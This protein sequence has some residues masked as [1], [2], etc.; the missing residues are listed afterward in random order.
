MRDPAV[1]I[2]T[3]ALFALA[4]SGCADLNVPNPNSPTGLE[5][6][7]TPDVVEGHISGAY[8]TWY[9]GVHHH[10]NMTRVANLSF[11]SSTTSC[12][13]GNSAIPRAPILND[14]T[15]Y[16]YYGEV[17]RTWERTYAALVAVAEG[18]GALDAHPEMSADLNAET[19]DG[20]L[21]LRAFGRTVQ[22]LGH[23]TLAVFY[24]KGVVRD[25]ATDLTADPHLVSYDQLFQ[26]ADGYFDDAIDLAESGDFTIPAAWMS[27]DVTSEE[28]AALLHAW[29]AI[30][31]ASLPR[32]EDQAVDW[33]AVLMDLDRSLTSTFAMQANYNAGWYNGAFDV[34]DG[35]NGW[36][37]ES[38]FILGMADQ[39]GRYQRWLSTP[40]RDRLPWFGTGRDDDP[41]L[42]VTPDTRFPR[43][44]TLAEQDAAPGESYLIPRDDPWGYDVAE[45]F[46]N[47]GRGTWRWSY[48]YNPVSWNYWYGFDH[49]VP[50]I[51]TAELD[52]LRAE[53]LLMTGDAAGAAALVNRYRTAHGLG[54]TDAAGTN[55]ACVPRLP[56]GTC[57]GLMEML[58]WEKRLEVQ[59]VGLFNAG[60]YWDARRWGDLYRGTPL[61]WPIPAGDLQRLGMDEYTFGGVQDVAPSASPG[62]GYGWPGEG[63]TAE[64]P[65]IRSGC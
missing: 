51:T 13:H 62:S 46:T 25:E 53:A 20:A 8:R 49:T 36:G 50:M 35:P 37:Y 33:T 60:W 23:A 57:G 24:D 7:N 22:A 59:S 42:I 10:T 2:L 64:M 45:H 54:A 30:F 32:W 39:S 44:S 3:A 27:V 43:G 61:Q 6:L 21:R 56:D 65:M 52:L 58:K 34:N 17:G 9:N 4:V 28:L 19:P 40:V 5:A 31:R 26:A 48:Y 41:F 11:E 38:Y 47:A 18:L 63:P 55:D 12:K 29:R 1:G 15:A 14:P 16:S